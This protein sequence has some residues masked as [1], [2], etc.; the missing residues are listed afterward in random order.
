MHFK[1]LVILTFLCIELAYAGNYRRS[2]YVARTLSG[3]LNEQCEENA[4]FSGQVCSVIT[5]GFMCQSSSYL[6]RMK[7]RQRDGYENP[8][9]YRPETNMMSR[10]KPH[11]NGRF[12]LRDNN[13]KNKNNEPFW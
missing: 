9:S 3:D 8:G 12:W 2:R 4:C 13:N 10:K 7:T 6:D 5:G 1:A 11:G